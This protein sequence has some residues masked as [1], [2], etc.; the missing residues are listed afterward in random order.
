MDLVKPVLGPPIAES[1]WYSTI[2]FLV[3]DFAKR[4]QHNGLKRQK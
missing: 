3:L 4:W 2:K 1:L